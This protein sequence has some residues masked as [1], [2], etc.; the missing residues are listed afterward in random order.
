LISEEDR[1]QLNRT[2][3]GSRFESSD[4]DLFFD[5]DT[6]LDLKKTRKKKTRK[7]LATAFSI[8]KK[9]PLARMPMDKQR[10]YTRKRISVQAKEQESVKLDRISNLAA[11]DSYKRE[12]AEAS[13]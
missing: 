3:N 5:D 1:R 9:L 7:S 12:E 10:K 4:A 8:K 13:F 6:S 2:L 11:D